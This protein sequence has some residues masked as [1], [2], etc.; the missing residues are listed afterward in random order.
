MS[1]TGI[2]SGQ[3]LALCSKKKKF[4]AIEKSGEIK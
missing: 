4:P 2:G 3:Y 1:A